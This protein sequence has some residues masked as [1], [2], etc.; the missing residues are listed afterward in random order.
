MSIT[1][2]RTIHC[3]RCGR[4]SQHSEDPLST[5]AQLRRD[6]KARG[7]QI[8]TGRQGED[9]CPP[10]AEQPNTERKSTT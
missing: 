3:D 10:C 6:A 9:T 7:W 2:V 4:W 5:T 8:G 1:T